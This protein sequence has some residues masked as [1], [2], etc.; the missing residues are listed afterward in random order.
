MS[1]L[2]RGFIEA[3]DWRTQMVQSYKLVVLGEGGVGKS[4]EEGRRER[5]GG[6]VSYNG[7]T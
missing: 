7:G 1:V 5:E 6:D 4:G 2:Q 3:G